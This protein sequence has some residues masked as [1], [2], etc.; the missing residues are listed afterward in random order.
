[1]PYCLQERNHEGNFYRSVSI[2][3]AKEQNKLR[4]VESGICKDTLR[5][6]L[7][8]I[9]NLNELMASF[10]TKLFYMP[11]LINYEKSLEHI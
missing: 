2:N 3:K 5:M 1:M 9:K 4:T 11:S 8:F 10:K 6:V 7:P